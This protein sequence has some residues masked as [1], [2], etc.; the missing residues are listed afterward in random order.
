MIRVGVCVWRG[1][2]HYI[3]DGRDVPIKEVFGTYLQSLSGTGVRFITINLGRDLT[4]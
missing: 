4:N 3:S 2:G 1:G